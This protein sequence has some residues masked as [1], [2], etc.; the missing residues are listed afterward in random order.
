MSQEKDSKE[1]INSDEFARPTGLM[2]NRMAKLEE[3]FNMLSSTCSL[4]AKTPQV[5]PSAERIKCLE[6]ELA[7][8]KKNMQAV[9]AK[10]Q[11]LVEALEQMKEFCNMKK[12]P[13]HKLHLWRA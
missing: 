10:Q 13:T 12:K 4:A 8:T 1:W 2:S 5:D 6:A 11:D 7:E 9:L 3:E